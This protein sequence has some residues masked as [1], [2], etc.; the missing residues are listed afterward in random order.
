MAKRYARIKTKKR[1]LKINNLAKF[2]LALSENKASIGVHK[3]QG[4]HNL[5][6]AIWNEFGATPFVLAT[7][8]KKKLADGT[9]TTLGAGTVLQIPA[10]PFVRLYLYPE[11]QR[12]VF[13]EY[14]IVYNQLVKEGVKSPISK[15]R[16]LLQ[17]IGLVAKNEMYDIILSKTLIPN[18]P[19]TIAIKG[20]D[21]PLF[22]TGSMVNAIKNKV[23]KAHG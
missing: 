13:E 22:K 12:K 17:Q 5:D 19:L 9:F 10:R 15:A 21:F 6:K 3:E 4:S 20:F 23:K 1:D 14:K 11:R 18:A 7:P 16:K 2:Y 8:M